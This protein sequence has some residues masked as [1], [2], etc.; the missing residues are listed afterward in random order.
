[1]LHILVLASAAAAQT[2]PSPPAA[3]TPAPAGQFSRWLDLQAGSLAARYK[4]A[5]STDTPPIYQVQ[6]QILARGRVKFDRNGRFAAGFRLQ[7]GKLFYHSWNSAGPGDGEA[8]ANVYLKE[9]F[10]SASPWKSIEIQFGGLGINRGESTEITGYSNNGYITGERIV[11]RSPGR[12]FFDEISAT[13]AYLGDL[14]KPGFFQRTGRFSQ[15]NYHQFLAS[16]KVT[17]RLSFSVDYTSQDGISTLRQALKI[18]PNKNNFIDTILFENYQRF[19]FHPAWGF[20]LTI[21]KNPTPRLAVIGGF[22]D[23]DRY[24]PAWNADKLGRGKRV[25]LS[26]AYNIWQ[27]F[28]VTF[29]AGKAFSNDFPVVNA[30]RFDCAVIYDV[31][32]ALKRSGLL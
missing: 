18:Y 4:R 31:L 29:F 15:M 1:M 26:V 27:D 24:F 23:I 10:V 22:V 3:P 13:G 17:E 6:Y 32:K 9:L 28:T 19:E 2:A 21:Q 11:I 8:A 12:L 16:K 25:Y 30:V 14:E 7:T 5:A 20:A